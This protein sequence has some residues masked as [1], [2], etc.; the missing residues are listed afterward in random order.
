MYLPDGDLAAGLLQS[1]D[2]RL[3]PRQQPENA[4]E[5]GRRAVAPRQRSRCR[6]AAD[7]GGRGLAHHDLVQP[8][9]KAARVAAGE[10]RDDEQQR[11]AAHRAEEKR[12]LTWI[13]IG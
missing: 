10:R 1:F 11:N 7:A 4:V 5:A 8:A 2:Q 13:E 9:G 6:V 3:A 12:E